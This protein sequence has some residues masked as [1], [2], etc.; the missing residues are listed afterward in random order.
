MWLSGKSVGAMGTKCGSHICM[1]GALGG[2][3]FMCHSLYVYAGLFLGLHSANER[4][5]YKV[6]P[7]LIGWAQT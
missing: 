2:V 7:S 1:V 5:R 6:T 4:R 3:T